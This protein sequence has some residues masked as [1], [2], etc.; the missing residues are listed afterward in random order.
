MKTNTLY[1]ATL[2]FS[3]SCSSEN[4]GTSPTYMELTEAVYASGNVYPRNEYKL[5]AQGDGVL[6]RQL[7]TEG[8]TVA[9]GQLLFEL[10]SNVPDARS[11]AATNIYRQSEANLAASSPVLKELEVQLRN[12]RTRQEND[13]V[14]FF[15]IKGLY[16]KNAASKADF[17]RTELAYRSSRNDVAARQ[18]ALIRTKNQLYVELQNAR[19]QYASSTD[20]AKNYR[21]RS[22]E[23]GKIYEI[24]KQPGELVRRAEAVALVGSPTKAY[25]QMAVDESDFTKMKLGQKVMIKVDAFDQKMYEAVVS[26]IYPKLNKL[27]QTFRVDADFTGDA[28]DGYYGLT[29]EAN[30]LISQ[31]PKALT[32]PKTYLYGAD[33]VWVKEENGEKKK[34]KIQKGAENLDL[35]EVKGGLTDKSIIFKP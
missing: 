21:L 24:Y 26:K 16:E 30:V 3:V 4:E 27:D 22:Y 13:S 9:K 10:E 32:I 2:I 29:V 31:N 25:V 11:Q 6:I 20:D 15:R 35:V 19:S 34:I 23:E 1:L 5:F 33:S 7:V 28:P 12:A 8:E 14:N 18:Q 17:E